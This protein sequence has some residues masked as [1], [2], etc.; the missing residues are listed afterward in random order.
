MAEHLD[1][2][3]A[4]AADPAAP[5][6]SNTI[7]ALELAGQMLRR[8]L[9]AFQN[10]A[11]SDT[12]PGLQALQA[13]S[14]RGWLRIRTRSTWTASCSRGFGRCMRMGGAGCGGWVAVGIGIDRLG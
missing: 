4:I 14:V 3:A 13:G 12:T 6:F 11:D 5:T 10:Q 9:M 1:E 2:V 7:V 8:V